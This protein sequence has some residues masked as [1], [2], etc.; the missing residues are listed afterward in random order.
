MMRTLLRLVSL[1]AIPVGL[2]GAL[3][4]AMA[5]AGVYMVVFE[6]VRPSE[7]IWLD[8]LAPPKSSA[9]LQVAIGAGLIGVSLAV[10]AA[11]RRRL[12]A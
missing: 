1:L 9:A 3:V 5:L 2:F 8:E 11:I 7:P 12:Q 4:V 6:G 10:R